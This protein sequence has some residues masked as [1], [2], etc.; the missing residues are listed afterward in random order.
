MNAFYIIKE[1][2]VI[3]KRDGEA[4]VL[5]E[6]TAGQWFG[7]SEVKLQQVR[8]RPSAHRRPPQVLQPP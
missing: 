5:K 6:L 3:V 8:A 7:E 2:T 1:G 4:A